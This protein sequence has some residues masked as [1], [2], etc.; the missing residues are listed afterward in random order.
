MVGNRVSKY[1]YVYIVM[2]NVR[3]KHERE[4]LLH[5]KDNAVGAR[6]V[7]VMLVSQHWLLADITVGLVVM[8]VA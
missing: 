6:L 4:K 5:L 7:V 2:A 8:L 1:C 3:E